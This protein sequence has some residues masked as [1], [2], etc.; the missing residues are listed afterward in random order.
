M[1]LQW[2]FIATVL[3]TEIGVCFLLMF[4]YISAY[5][6]QRIFRSRFIAAFTSHAS[7]YF[8][9]FVFLLVILFA[10][11]IR[12]MN[13]YQRQHLSAELSSH[14]LGKMA[15]DMKLFRSQ[16][17]FYLTGFTFLLWLVLRRLVMLISTQ[18]TLEAE[19]NAAQ[20]QAKSATEA[21]KLFMEDKEN[22]TNEDSKD[23]KDELEKKKL[24]VKKLREELSAAEAN[25]D[26][27]KKQ[28]EGTNAEYDR[29]LKENATLQELIKKLEGIG[30]TKKDD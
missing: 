15:I 7:F 13:K 18:A 11:S 10:D 26:A 4:P 8:Y 5:R 25:V 2:T 3:Y 9:A 29:L 23:L 27:M 19:A 28:A 6:W 22:K 12:E 1:S 20:K 21:A 30:E 24:D 16:R 14:D 17:N